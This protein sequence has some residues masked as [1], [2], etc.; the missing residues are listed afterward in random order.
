MT[1]NLFKKPS[2]NGDDSYGRKTEKMVWRETDSEKEEVMM[3]S[4]NRCW[5]RMAKAQSPGRDNRG[6]GMGQVDSH[7]AGQ[8]GRSW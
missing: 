6:K 4:W 8:L 5:Y 3:S 1:K 7:L 2:K